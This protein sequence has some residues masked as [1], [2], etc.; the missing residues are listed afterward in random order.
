MP[1]QR[2]LELMRSSWS[3]PVEV[4]ELGEELDVF[5]EVRIEGTIEAKGLGAHVDE[6]HTC[7][8]RAY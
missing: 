1:F 2:E 5:I 6:L 7:F 8:V 3:L 4:I